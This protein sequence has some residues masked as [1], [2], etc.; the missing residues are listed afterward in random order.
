[1][2]RR[3]RMV[4]AV[5]ASWAMLGTLPAL[6]PTRASMVAAPGEFASVVAAPGG[7]T[8]V[9]AARVLDTRTGVGG[10]RGAVPAWGTVRLPVLGRGGVP[11]VGVSAVVLNVT[12]TGP[13]RA[14]FVTVFADGASRPATSNL[15]FVAGQT[16]PNL[17]VAPVGSAGAVALYNGSGGTVQLVADVSGYVLAGVPSVAGAFTSVVAARVL[18]TRTGVGGVRGA[19][20]AWGTVRLPVLG[21]GG[22]PAV[23]VSAVVLNVTVTGPTRAGFVTVFADG[24]SRPATSNLNFVAGQTVPNLV[25][26]P[27]GSAGAVALYNGS[28][29]TVQLV[30]DV[31]GYVRSQPAPSPGSYLGRG[32][33]ACS[34]PSSAL[35]SAWLGTSPYRAIGIYIGGDNRACSQP[36]LTASWVSTQQTAG[37]HLL[38]IYLG[39]QPYCTTSTKPDRFTALDAVSAGSAAA[40]DA[41]GQAHALGLAA[42]S[43]VYYDMEAYATTDPVCRK[44]VLGFQSAWTRRLHELG[45]R[46]GFYSSLASGIKDQVDV[47]TST[48]Y[49]RPDYIWFARYDGVATVSDPSIPSTYWVHR[50]IKQYQSPVQTGGPETYGGLSLS[51]DRDQIDVGP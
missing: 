11:A 15:N 33:D 7:F 30:A 31:S 36:A 14:G 13:T 9:V 3:F 28:G 40:D 24:A 37:W 29:G 49:V 12:V 35:M 5:L 34:A 51:V 41:S 22:V 27:V 16:V 38:P 26:A 50:R 43:T 10:V 6:G 39:P 44:A 8:S 42:G 17:V 25:V 20:P 23:G 21:R 32:F 45:Y 48:A 46:S 19:V 4:L 2:S 18:D 47:Y 1:M